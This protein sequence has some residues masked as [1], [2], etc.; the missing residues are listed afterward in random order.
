ME[1]V[2][3][4][5]EQRHVWLGFLRH[6]DSHVSVLETLNPEHEISEM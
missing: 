1:K 5:L 6:R 3:E 4:K 2:A